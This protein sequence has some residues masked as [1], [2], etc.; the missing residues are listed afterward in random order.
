M[1]SL[2]AGAQIRELK[3]QGQGKGKIKAGGDPDNDNMAGAF[4]C[5]I[6]SPPGFEKRTLFQ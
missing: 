6:P 5:Y 1:R 4:C 2:P 3:S